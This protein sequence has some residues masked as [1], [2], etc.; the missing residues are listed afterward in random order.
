MKVQC[1]RCST[2][3][4]LKYGSSVFMCSACGSEVRVPLTSMSTRARLDAS[5]HVRRAEQVV[6]AALTKHAA[7]SQHLW[8]RL[9]KVIANEE[10]I[11]DRRVRGVEAARAR[12]LVRTALNTHDVAQA[13]ETLAHWD[14]LGL[15]LASA[16]IRSSLSKL[17]REDDLESHWHCLARAL[18]AADRTDLE[19]WCE[20]AA[21]HGFREC[22][23]PEVDGA[24]RA[25]L[26]KE[27]AMLAEW[28]YQTKLKARAAEAHAKRD[29]SELR[30]LAAEAKFLG[31]DSS[32]VDAVLALLAQSSSAAPAAS[33]DITDS[34]ANLKASVIKDELARRGINSAGVVE[35]DELVTLLRHAVAGAPAT[36][37]RPTRSVS[38]E[39]V[40]TSSS[41]TAPHTARPSTSASSSSG[42]TAYTA[43]T[44]R[45][46]TTREASP[47]GRPPM[48]APGPPLPGSQVS[49]IR[50]VPRAYAT[51]A[52][53]TFCNQRP[54][55]AS[56]CPRPPPPP[57]N[58]S[59]RFS[60]S[61][62]RGS[63]SQPPCD[64]RRS[65]SRTFAQ[66][67]SSPSPS[68]RPPPEGASPR[69]P[70]HPP[71]G[72]RGERT[73]QRH[74]SI[75]GRQRPASAGPTAPRSPPPG[76]LPTTRAAALACLGLEGKPE[77]DEIRRAYK[78]AAMK[79]HPDRPQNHSCMEEAKQQFQQVRA[80]FDL[81]Q[82]PVR[83][84]C[85]MAGG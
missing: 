34:F 47:A 62:Q 26:G 50:G 84:L 9:K 60:G 3:R 7:T 35:K 45:P 8:E 23:P 73:A 21:A 5:E 68:P 65:Q 51:N 82:A 6:H 29:A 52:F 31:E 67:S 77:T 44:A 41:T 54:A 11:W 36:I 30:S 59:P 85:G 12:V 37:D 69:P 18:A 66:R 75:P 63:A 4:M 79:W 71:P 61:R 56:A 17:K 27:R 13:A 57:P 53:N 46:S 2:T 25:L 70:T 78:Q 83:N 42:D 20:E 80:A 76:M 49:G 40:S 48:V 24:A 58:A 39:S 38:K 16:E 33:N 74:S 14:A 28:E 19:F 72:E 15:P 10:G 64:A 22:L 55:S 81:L 43:S 1:K 32:A